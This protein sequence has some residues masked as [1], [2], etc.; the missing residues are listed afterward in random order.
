VLAFLLLHVCL[1]GG[2]TAFKSYFDQQEMPVD[3]P[4]PVRPVPPTSLTLAVGLLLLGLPLAMLVGVNFLAVCAAILLLGFGYSL[5]VIR[6]KARPWSSLLVISI[7][8]GILGFDAGVL[9]SRTGA[10][11]FAQPDLLLGVL[12]STLLATGLYAL[13]QIHG[14]EEDAA[15]GDRTFAVAFGPK[16][17]SWLALILLAAAGACAVVLFVRRFGKWQAVVAAAL[18][19][20]VWVRIALWLRPRG[21]QGD[22]APTRPGIVLAHATPTR[23]AIRLAY[24]ASAGFGLFLIAHLLGR[25]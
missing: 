24:A 3:C 21:S 17:C 18:A 15:R 13:V 5:P 10:S 16:V 8:Q 11:Y 6:W 4:A 2:A 25:V 19:T 7:G 9:A 1:Y 20:L 12:T 23:R 22:V 14:I